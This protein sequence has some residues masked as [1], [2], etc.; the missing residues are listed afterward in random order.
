MFVNLL[1]SEFV[2]KH[3]LRRRVR[4]WIFIVAFVMIGGAGI[5]AVRAAQVAALAQQVTAES[6]AHPDLRRLLVEL[7]RAEQQLKDLETETAAV[8]RLKNDKR[9]LTLIGLC[10]QSSHRAAGQTQLRTVTIRQPTT[11]IPAKPPEPAG[12]PG[13]NRPVE[14]AQCGLLAI[15]GTAD[16]AGTISAFVAALREV[17][18]FSQVTLKGS[19]EIT[20]AGVQTRQF[21]IECQY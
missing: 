20:T 7:S 14:T 19:T 17:G 6:Q 3:A 11:G 9:V 13:N 18:V 2:M 1:P 5:Y 21:Q 12:K 4:I 8:Q 15:D 16:E 10:T